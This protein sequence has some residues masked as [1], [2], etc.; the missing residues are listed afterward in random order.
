MSSL[1]HQKL[2]TVGDIVVVYIDLSN[3]EI[4]ENQAFHLLD[5]SEQTRVHRFRDRSAR[6]EFT[7]CRA[8]LRYHLCK[9]ND[10]KNKEL[11]IISHDNEKPVAYINGSK[12]RYE[13]N[14]S[15]TTGHGLLALAPTRR[16][17]IDVEHRNLQVDI[18]GPI[19]ETFAESEKQ[20]LSQLETRDKVD[21][22]LRIWTAKEALIKATGEGFRADTT[23]FS[24]PDEFFRGSC[25]K[26]SPFR[27]PHYHE[28]EWTILN[29]SST[30][31]VATLVYEVA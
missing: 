19:S 13:F 22:F 27:L 23:S 21:V 30:S 7:L 1:W 31:Y 26:F 14:L 9:M 4:W 15:H 11:R 18:D 10:C 8:A 5:K 2:T 20:A 29:L 3:N 28:F 12:I 25:N 6:R 17:G 16:L 24:V